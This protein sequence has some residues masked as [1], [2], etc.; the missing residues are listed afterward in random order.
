MT[1]P[2]LSLRDLRTYFH[3]ESGL[4]RSVDGVS[5]DVYPGET[6][7]VVGES[8]CGKSVTAL[9]VLRLIRPPGRIEAGSQVLFDGRD[10][11]TLPER[12]LRAI[13]GNRIAMIFQ[14][15]MTA[16]NPVFTVGDQVAEVVRV[17]GA[18][19]RKEAWARAVEMLAG[20]GIAS[21]AERASQ[22]PHQLSGG[23]R[24]R[25]AARGARPRRAPAPPRRSGRR[26][27]RRG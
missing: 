9:S 13:R 20:V 23:M 27:G 6:L 2:V 11:L 3:A 25:V 4:A 16:L 5:L 22:Y 26:R 19:S 1:A 14:E 10:L 12:E 21:P 7:G 15:P 24:Q 18:G 17:H 8:G